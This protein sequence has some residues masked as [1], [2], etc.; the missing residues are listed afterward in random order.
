MDVIVSLLIQN[1]ANIQVQILSDRE[2]QTIHDASL[3]IL[4]KTGI[5]VHHDEVLKLVAEAGAQVDN[6]SKVAHLPEQLVMDCI[7]LAKKQYILYGR[8]LERT[9][10]FGYGDFVL[11]S[12]PGQYG[13]IDSHSG[14]L[15]SATI[16]DARDAICLGDALPNI[17]IVG[18]MAQPEEVSQAYRE[19]LLTAELVKGTS[20]P[21]RTWVFNRRTARYVLE[22]Y[23][24]IAGGEKALRD[25]PMIEAFLEPISPLQLP[26]DGLDVMMEFIQAG[27][28]VSIGP[29]AMTSGTAPATL[30]GTLAQENAEI[31]AGVVVSQLLAEGTAVTYGG[32]PHIMDPRTSICSFGSPEQMLMA[33]ACVQMGRFYGFPVYINVGLTDA[34]VLDVQAGIEKG[35]SMMLGALAGADMF[36][37]AGICGTDHGASL[38]WLVIDDELMAYVKRVVRGFEVNT[39]TIATEVVDTVGPAGTYLAEEHTVKHFRDEL[40]LPNPAWTRATWDAWEKEGRSSMADRALKKVERIMTTHK[41][42]PMDEALAGEIDRIVE[43]ARREL[44]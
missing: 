14:R 37:H 19:V 16:Q 33:Q 23:R 32:I 30:A 24:T 17:T 41:A 12:S 5:M 42:K 27:Q 34:K 7:A 11:M 39:N 20:K 4:K 44:A 25:H 6:H 10:R 1:M 2:I 15:R 18:S 22:I 26:H 21:T 13:W 40:W 35:A 38:A 9:A 36:G 28:P 43:C 3:A 29:M 8:D 31:L